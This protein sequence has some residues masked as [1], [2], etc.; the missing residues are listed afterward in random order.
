M[1]L[2]S[3]ANLIVHKPTCKKDK[4]YYQ[5]YLLE[6]DGKKKVPQDSIPGGKFPLKRYDPNNMR[7]KVGNRVDCMIGRAEWA[8]GTVLQVLDEYPRGRLH[9][10]QVK[11][12]PPRQPPYDMIWAEWDN[13]CQIRALEDKVRPKSRKKKGNRKK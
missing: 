8:H 2:T 4:A 5:D 9:A 7:F 6:K 3:I 10:Y 11:L 12:D 13:D 1:A